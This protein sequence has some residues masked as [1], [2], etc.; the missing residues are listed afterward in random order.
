MEAGGVL[1]HLPALFHVMGL[2]CSEHNPFR[3]P[4]IIQDASEHIQLIAA[5]G[6]PVYLY[7]RRIFRVAIVQVDKDL[8]AVQYVDTWLDIQFCHQ[9]PLDI[10][11]IE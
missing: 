9:M 2:K 6:L 10:T 1:E 8:C 11:V 3:Y 7:C 5:H 4:G